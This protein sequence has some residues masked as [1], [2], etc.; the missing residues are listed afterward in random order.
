MDEP[1]IVKELKEK[2]KIGMI[3]SYSNYGEYKEMGIMEETSEDVPNS[4]ND[5]IE[6]FWVNTPPFPAE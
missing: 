1:E 4:S 3:N 5:F 2:E 6:K